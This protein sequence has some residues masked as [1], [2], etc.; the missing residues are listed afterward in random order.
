MARKVYM[1]MKAKCVNIR[2]E[3]ARSLCG[4]ICRSAQSLVY[5]SKG[6]K[7][8]GMKNSKNGIKEGESKRRSRSTSGSSPR[9]EA[10]RYPKEV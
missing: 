5:T 3:Y 9:P 1:F 10:A 6:R 4:V 7:V 8:G 2:G